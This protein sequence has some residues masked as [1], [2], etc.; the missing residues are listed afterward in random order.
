VVL[1]GML[2]LCESISSAQALHFVSMWQGFSRNQATWQKKYTT[3]NRW[4]QDDSQ[5]T[6]QQ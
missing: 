4:L 3:I 6:Y 2:H 1:E 5:Q